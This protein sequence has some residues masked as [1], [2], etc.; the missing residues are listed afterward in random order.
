[1]SK[2][3]PRG[4]A[5]RS[6]KAQSVITRL[7]LG[8]IRLLHSETSL[9]IKGG[10]PPGN[11]KLGFSAE[12]GLSKDDKTVRGVIACAV[13]SCYDGEETPSVFIHCKYELLYAAQ[14]GKLPTKGE[15]KAEQ[16]Q[17]V[18]MLLFQA[19]PYVREFIHRSCLAMLLPPIILA[20]L[21]IGTDESG[22]IV[23]SVSL[24][25]GDKAKINEKSRDDA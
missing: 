17:I 2:R 18:N 10:K 15:L 24:G 8:N 22:A 19:W 7:R 25:S 21:Q 9:T 14:D 4:G 13:D 16:K 20:P 11:A 3:K 5:T 1:M 6:G 12:I 23:V